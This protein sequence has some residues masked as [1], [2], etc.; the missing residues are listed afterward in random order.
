MQTKE[1]EFFLTPNGSEIKLQW[2]ADGYGASLS[3]PVR[4]NAELLRKRSAEVRTA[5]TAMNEYVRRNPN[6]SE[7]RDAGW[8]SY[9]SA[10]G[11]IVDGGRALRAA[12]LRSEPGARPLEDALASISSGA[13]MK[14][15]CSDEEVTFPFGFI[16]E[17]DDMGGEGADRPADPDKSY[18]PS[19]AD[20]ARF[21][22][23]RFRISMLVEGSGCAA[24]DLTVNPDTLR[25]LYALHKTELEASVP[26]LGPECD[27]LR[28]LLK[29]RVGDY[30]DWNS[31]QRAWR[32]IDTSNSIV[33]VLAHSDGDHL[34]L[35]DS[36]LESLQFRDMLEKRSSVGATLLILNCCLSATGAA[37]AS[38][39]SAVARRGFCGLVGTEA[40]ILNSKALHF[41]TLLL[42]R[43]LKDGEPLGQAFD[44]VQQD[45]SLFPLNLFYTCYA[46]RGFKLREPMR[47][48]S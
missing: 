20:F 37:G 33:F 14:I 13:A 43:L 2:R 5:L 17:D 35:Q 24:D 45:A 12:L 38:L 21:W 39:L 3:K 19:H 48:D 47:F 18:R 32:S 7:E 34:K 22:L 15:S 40:E 28:Q 6:L 8:K 31:A 11:E 16:Y 44:A 4:I 25:A 27:T 30:Y 26:D 9:R 1:I 36:R 10:L 29:L 42:R 23:S 41:G 46:D